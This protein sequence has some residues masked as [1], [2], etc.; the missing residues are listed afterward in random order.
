MK[1]VISLAVLVFSSSTFGAT[2]TPIE[3]MSRASVERLSARFK[4]GCDQIVR[5]AKD[6]NYECTSMK[7][8]IDSRDSGESVANSIKQFLYRSVRYTETAQARAVRKVESTIAKAIRAMIEPVPFGTFPEA[9]VEGLSGLAGNIYSLT[10]VK[11]YSA[12]AQS[13]YGHAGFLVIHDLKKEE[14][15]FTGIGYSE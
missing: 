10:D 8:K 12:T 1:I 2:F 6:E 3:V 13:E 9:E 11:V 15:L 4:A 7:A 5:Y 14:L